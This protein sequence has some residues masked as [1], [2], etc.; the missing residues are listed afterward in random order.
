L[1]TISSLR[2]ANERAVTTSP[3]K[4]TTSTVNAGSSRSAKKPSR[5]SQASTAIR[6]ASRA[7][8][9]ASCAYLTGCPAA[10]GLMATMVISAV[11]ASGSARG[12]LGMPGREQGLFPAGVRQVTLRA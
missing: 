10:S 4:P 8:V 3:L 1:A 9:L 5:S 6:P 2:L 11:V 7:S 12:T